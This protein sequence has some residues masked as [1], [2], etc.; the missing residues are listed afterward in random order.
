M[1]ERLSIE[2]FNELCGYLGGVAHVRLVVEVKTKKVHFIDAHQYPAHAKFIAHHILKISENEM[3]EH[4]D[5]Y[6]K[7][8]YYG[9]K[10]DLYL[11]M[12]SLHK[13][14]D[15][16]FFTI[17]T[18]EVDDMQIPMLLDFFTIIDVNIPQD[19]PLYLKPNNNFQEKEVQN[20]HQDLLPRIFMHELMKSKSYVP[21]HIGEAKGRLRY[22]ASKEEYKKNLSTICWYDIVAMERVPDSIPRVS[23]IIN[24]SYTTPLSHTNILATGWQI[25]NAIDLHIVDQIQE[26]AL[27]GKWVHYEVS[28]SSHQINL[29]QIEPFNP[30]RPNWATYKVVLDT[31]AFEKNMIASLNDIRLNDRSSYGTKAASLGEVNYV[32]HHPS[33][34]ILGFYQIPRAPRPNLMPFLAALIN[35]KE[36]EDL[37]QAAQTF[38]NSNVIVPRGIAIPFS[39]NRDFLQK[40]PAV[41]QL[42]GKLKM[43][44]ELGAPVVDSI[45]LELQ[46]M[47]QR[48][49]MSTEMQDQINEK[50]A[51]YLS[52]VETFVVR[53]SSNAEDLEHFSA[54]GIYESYN[55]LTSAQNIFESIKKVWASLVSPRSVKLRQEVG[56]SL[57]D[58]YMG[59]I[60][61]E[62]V[63][64][65]LG[66]V[67]VSANPLKPK[68]DFRNVFIN[69]SNHSSIEVV[70]GT[71]KPYQLLYNVVEGASQTLLKDDS[72]ANLTEQEDETLAKL[73][74]VS[75]LLQSHFSPDFTYKLPVDIE[76]AIQ[77]NKIRL[78]QIRPYA[79]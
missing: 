56:I 7:T 3:F 44:L 62:E 47:I 73:A 41:Q 51:E 1:S 66:G 42:I 33:K 22:F 6:N 10:R 15:K 34:K 79:Q 50:I 55:H 8:F 63:G 68:D 52:G 13:G 12:L 64:C 30:K 29:T 49:Q 59:V 11:G 78:L 76:W 61:Q 57:D 19:I 24:L 17:E 37:F 40:S 2:R 28:N 38:L 67:L 54:A 69:A 23:G 36:G 25:P 60:I 53:S 21:L 5:E 74:V 48:V 72:L 16:D 75:K 14:E 43:A 70:Q 58:C 77:D 31:P 65:D 45:C 35:A 20:I 39:F 4:I 27:D 32:L 18:T 71:D 46:S 9:P 26:Q